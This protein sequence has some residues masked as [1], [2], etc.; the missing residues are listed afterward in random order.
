MAKNLI[1][2]HF[3]APLNGATAAKIDIQAGDGNLMID[4]LTGGDELASGELQYLENQSPPLRTLISREGQATLMLKGGGTR[5]SWFRLPWAAC[6]GATDWQ[7]HLNPTISSDIT[8]HSDGGNLHLNLDGMDVRS[9]AADTGGG[10]IDVVLPDS[11]TNLLVS[12]GTGAGNVVVHISN[13]V[14]AR[15]QATAGLGK[16]IIDPRFG[17]TGDNTYQSDDFDHASHK[18]EI[19]VGSGAGNVS[20]NMK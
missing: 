16:V 20:V 2:D 6:N 4:Q 8:A 19:K 3:S 14:A 12:A 1:T 17:K 7:I 15:I 18:V 11:P 9:V 10:N 13:G 5:Q